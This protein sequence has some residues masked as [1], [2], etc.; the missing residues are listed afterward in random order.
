MRTRRAALASRCRPIF[1]V[2]L[3]VLL[4]VACGPPIDA[5]SSEHHTTRHARC[6]SC[7]VQDFA[8]AMDPPHNGELPTTCFVCHSED[9]W[10]PVLLDHPSFALTEGHASVRCFDCHRHV[11]HQNRVFEGL[12]T[13]C[14][15]CHAADAD[16]ANETRTWHAE[17]G[18]QCE[19]CHTRS[20]WLPSTHVWPPDTGV[21]DA[22]VP[23]PLDTGSL[24]D[25]LDGIG[26]ASMRGHSSVSI[27]DGLGR[28]ARDVDAGVRP[29]RHP[30]RHR[31]RD[32]GTEATPEETPPAEEP[33]DTVT[34]ASGR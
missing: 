26:G 21:V 17:L 16:R 28:V 4:L 20:E 34:R 3:A 25:G 13:D 11:G 8:R 24:L 33:I 32:A 29:A 19:S 9:E 27:G 15:S 1:T 22:G 18:A 2:P 23:Q 10:S 5:R 6:V 12:S 14:A 30:H 31:H 7:H